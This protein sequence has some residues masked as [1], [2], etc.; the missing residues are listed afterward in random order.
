MTELEKDSA[1]AP[2][3]VTEQRLAFIYA[4]ALLNVCEREHCVDEVLGELRGLV[5]DVM[6]RDPQ[7]AA[8]FTSGAIG[9]RKR[10]EALDR[11]FSGRSH[12][13]VLQ[14]LLVLN[15][16]DR[17]M[18]LRETVQEFAALNDRR[19]RRFP[20]HVRTTVPLTEDQRQRLTDNL[21][22]TFRL[23]PQLHETIDPDLLGGMIMRV[24]D[25]LF[26][27]SMRTRLDEVHKTLMESSS[28][29]I[30]SGRNRFS[31]Q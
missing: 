14:F 30:Q 5:S 26:D 10:N 20:V 15:D 23:E 18:L 2:A 17:L 13:L 24:G 16:H 21:R 12:P 4:E 8:F 28:H 9:R 22:T 3:D 19:H 11:A 1:E 7:M 27:G 31:D 25:W 29:E 6:G